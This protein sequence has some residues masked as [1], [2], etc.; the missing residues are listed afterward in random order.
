MERVPRVLPATGATLAPIADPIARLRC[1]AD[2]HRRP[3][4]PRCGER[5]RLLA[6][7]R[8][9]SGRRGGFAPPLSLPLL[10]ARAVGLGG[11]GPGEQ[12]ARHACRAGRRRD[13]TLAREA[14]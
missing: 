7:R 5:A 9:L 12:A 13:L 6:R 1:A 14:P 2:A 10:Q 11:G 4:R 8:A 3:A